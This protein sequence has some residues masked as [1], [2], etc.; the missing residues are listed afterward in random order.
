[1]FIA[2]AEIGIRREA[3]KQEFS[4]AEHR[5]PTYADMVIYHTSIFQFRLRRRTRM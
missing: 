5:T 2:D 1:M 4:I 3:S